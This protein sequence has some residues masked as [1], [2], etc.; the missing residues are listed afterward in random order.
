MNLKQRFLLL[1]ADPDVSPR[2]RQEFE[3]WLSTGRW[4]TSQ[5]NV[6]KIRSLLMES[7]TARTSPR[8]A[9]DATEDD[10]PVAQ[11]ARLLRYESGLTVR[12]ALEL[13]SDALG[14]SRTLPDRTAFLE[15][16]RRLFAE[17]GAANVLSA[18]HQIRNQ[19][20]HHGPDASWSLKH[21]T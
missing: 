13:L 7:R 19:M 15:G 10:A 4:R 5:A 8:A 11:V 14:R 21:G 3:H 17:Y 20:A 12:Q 6:E 18:A 2:E 9:V 16:V 1:L